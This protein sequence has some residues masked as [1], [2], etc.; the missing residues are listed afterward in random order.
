MIDYGEILNH[1]PYSLDKKEK[2]KFLTECLWELTKHHYEHCQAYKRICDA[3]RFDIK[4]IT[5]Y[6]DIPFLPVRLFK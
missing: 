2:E 1:E 5:S 4:Q 3:E 6:Y